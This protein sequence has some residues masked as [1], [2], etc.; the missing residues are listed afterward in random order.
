M[1]R[2]PA[3]NNRGLLIVIA[4]LL[5]L[6]VLGIGAVA[7]W[8]FFDGKGPV[9]AV[10]DVAGPQTYRI[11][12][13]FTLADRY[14]GGGGGGCSGDGGF[15]DISQGTQVTVTDSAGATVALGLLG[16]GRIE[17]GTC[18]FPFE[19]DGV[20]AGKDF[21]GIEVSHRGAVKYLEDEVKSGS[22]KLTLG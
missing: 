1:P 2:P 4:A 9:E 14:S 17:N 6:L 19:V 13:T 22:L 18:V 15:R 20:P 10:K 8:Y 21:Y 16:A 7:V 3:S 12:G 5:G 11:T